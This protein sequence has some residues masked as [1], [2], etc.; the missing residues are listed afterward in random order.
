MIP[1][2]STIGIMGG[3]QLG[4]ML[5]IAAA[6]MGYRTHIYA[7]GISGPAMEVAARW[8]RGFYEDAQAVAL[9]AAQVDVVTYEFENVEVG[10]L[11]RVAGVYPN[12]RALEVAQDRAI[13]KGFAADQGGRTAPW[14]MVDSLTDLNR[15]LTELGTPAVL[16]TRRFGYDGKGQVRITDSARAESAWI[17]V[18]EAPSILEGHVQFTTEF[19]LLLARSMEGQI[20]LYDPIVNEH[21]DGIL[22]RSSVPA[23]SLEQAHIEQ[24]AMLAVR[25]ADT[26]DY[27]GVLACEYFDTPAGVVFN[28]MAPRVHNS[29]HWTIAGAITSQFENH[30][31]AI[32]GLSLGSARLTGGSAEMRNL[33]GE[34]ADGWQRIIEDPTAHLHLYGK[35]TIRPGRKM[36][37]VTR[38][39]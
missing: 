5:A 7:P 12:P 22:R 32:C 39:G 3:G 33:I 30:I 20:E 16:K 10:S 36:G 2:G 9:F 1:P 17:A 19:S 15:A 11:L 14:R 18:G 4:R 6:N 38:V 37:H 27:V 25:M 23:T 26:L 28:E 24:A 8:T 29:G 31:R 35:A 21:R 13:E 34:E